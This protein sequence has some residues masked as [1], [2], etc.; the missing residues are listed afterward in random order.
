M[1][2]PC[3]GVSA[4]S[5]MDKELADVHLRSSTWWTVPFH[6]V[7]IFILFFECITQGLFLS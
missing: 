3:S 1:V 6:K 7:A 4:S 2:Q 5:G